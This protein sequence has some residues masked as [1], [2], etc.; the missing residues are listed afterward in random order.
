MLICSPEKS[1]IKIRILLYTSNILSHF[2]NLLLFL[3]NCLRNLGKTVIY[4]TLMLSGKDKHVIFLVISLLTASSVNGQAGRI[5]KYHFNGDLQNG[6]VI[7][8]SQD[9]VINYAIS[10]L[11]FESITNASGDF[12]KISIPG[13]NPTSDPGKP[14]LPVLS[15][16]ISVPENNTISIKISDITTERIIPASKNF[17]GLLYPRQ[18]GATKVIQKQKADFIIDNA[19]YSKRG[20][21]KSD[22][23]KVEYIGKVRNRQLATL[24]I[25]PVRYNPFSNELEVIKSMKIDITFTPANDSFTAPSKGSSL[26]FNQSVDKG[27]LNYNPSDVI[28]GY[29]D[30]PV[31]MIIIT[32]PAF[33]KH[34]APFYKWKTQKGYK[35]TILYKGTGL[36]GNTFAQLKDTITEIYNSATAANPA[37]EYLL[38]IGDVNRIPK[39]DGTSNISDMYY[40]EFDGNGDYIPDMYIGRLPVADTI[41]LKTAI[42]KII[43]YE[44]FE[45]A[46]TNKFYNRTLVTAG[47]DAT[48]ANYMNGQVKYLA[49][50]YLNATNKIDGYNFYY[51]QSYSSEDSIMKLIKKGVSFINYSGHGDAFGWLDP[52]LR[53]TD[54]TLL[55][56]K[57]MYPFVISNACRTAQYNTPGSFGNSMIVT[58]DNGAV[59]Y[60]GCSN[61]SYWDEDYY[62]SVGVGNPNVDPK[63]AE[64]G[65]GALDRLFHTHNESPSDWYLSMGQVNYAGNLAVSESTS[66]RKKY[67]WETY[68][69]LG[70]PST[71]PF[72]GTPDAFKISLPDTLPNGIKSLSMTIPPFSYMAVSHFDTLWD[73]SFASPSGSVVLDLPGLANDSC[74]IVITGQNKVPLIKTIHFADVNKEFINLTSSSINDASSNNNGLADYGESLFIKLIISNLG[75]INAPGLYAKLTTTAEWVTINNDSVYIGTLAGKS[76]IVL[77]TCFG[78]TI[79]DLVPDKGYITLNLSLIDSKI[80]KNY[81]IDICIHA[82]VLEILNCLI[83]DS[84]T[85]NGNYVAEPGETFNLLFKVRNSGGSSIAGTFNIVN[86]PPGVTIFHPVVN[87]GPLQFGEVTEIPVSVKL[88]LDF[89]R[90]GSFDVVS[91]LDCSPYIKNKSFTIPVGKTRESFEYQ[92][93]TIYPWV[94]SATF[95]WITTGS[96]SADGQFSA[97]SGIIPNG[98][99]SMLK[100]TV[101]IPVKDTIIFSVKVSSEINFDFLYFRLN[102]TQMFSISGETEWT[103]KKFLMK[104]GFNL[105]EWFYKKDETVSKG[106]DCAWLDNIR[107]PLTAFNNKDL[108][109]GK[110]VA[111]QPGKSYNQEQ[112]TAEIINLGSDTVK[113]FNLAYQVNSNP[114]I[115]QN[116]IKKINPSDTVAITFSQSANLTGNGTYNIKVYGLNNNDNFPKN[117]TTHL[118]LVNTSIFTPVE[119]PE[120]KVRIIP[121]PFRQSFRL[122]IVSKINEEIRITI[123]GQ[124]GQALWEEQFNMVPGLNSFTITPEGLRTGFYTIKITGKATLKAA[125]VVK[126]E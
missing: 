116:F 99:E 62:W 48:Y 31:K 41:E 119:N 89:A 44:K 98:T 105:L 6:N 92:K 111:P 38:I 16:L 32:D 59:G 23:V 106:T 86:L 107:F 45:Y 66:P 29:S 125:R 22:T 40:G 56:N 81:T 4:L 94:N 10:E 123:F 93:M 20:I 74:L 5:Y 17:K 124:S 76:Q 46:D 114:P 55:Q 42:G 84:G 52:A 61:D 53:A 54:I 18:V 39:S 95:P 58:A 49:S 71:I 100:M 3:I 112:I 120:N 15:R 35:L 121:N 19:E 33:K 65:L 7:A 51:P 13:H 14:E 67:Y 109:T 72:I 90:G 11:N 83:D 118:R 126:I 24:L 8:G 1:T 78:I 77:P 26:L 101:N 108:K 117:D 30:Q 85:G 50:N 43:Q 68:T 69:L 36:A 102:G 91:L 9:L 104:E 57:N 60:I 27:L 25:Y 64:T 88:A 82:P 79:S 63:Y 2:H 73:A 110:I 113:N 96:Q 12:F 75:L 122:E 37:P 80:V 47:N 87:T 97:R 70:D 115:N 28:T 21:I 34:L 103:E